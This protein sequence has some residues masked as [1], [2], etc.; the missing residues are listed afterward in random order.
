MRRHSPYNYAF[1]N[2]IRFV[3]PDGMAPE[4]GGDPVPNPTIS[5][6]NAKKENSNRFMSS[7]TNDDGSKRYHKGTDILAKPGTPI[8]S[9]LDGKVV[10][11]NMKTENNTKG[12]SGLG[13]TVTVE[14]TLPDGSKVYI[15]YGHLAKESANLDLKG[16]T[17]KA[18]DQIAVAG[19]TGNV[20]GR[21]AEFKHVHIEAAVDN[22]FTDDSRR[23]AENYMD[24]K[25]DSQGKAIKNESYVKP[26]YTVTDNGNR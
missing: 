25:F 19:N 11:V 2:P 13:N 5:N 6:D 18:G 15:K 16:K 9:I 24:T 23:N 14:S 8:S 4:Q 22:K 7:R 20:V 3:D 17:V 26:T 12:K 21:D 10:S 1:D